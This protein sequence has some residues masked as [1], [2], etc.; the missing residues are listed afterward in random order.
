MVNRNRENENVASLPTAPA[1]PLHVFEAKDRPQPRVDLGLGDGM[2]VGVGCL[3]ADP[4]YDAS[5]TVLSHN[6]IRG[7]AGA[8]LLNAELAVQ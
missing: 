7:A 2:T 6:L 4:V 8:C 5:F 1:K 3:A